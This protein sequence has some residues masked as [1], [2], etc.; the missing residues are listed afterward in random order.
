MKV[1]CLTVTR[2][3]A[4][5]LMMVV[6][7]VVGVFAFQ[8]VFYYS[9]GCSAFLAFVHAML[10]DASIHQVAAEGEGDDRVNA[11]EPEAQFS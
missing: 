3:E 6:S 4:S 11:L 7:I 8:E 2:K 9:I 10:R 5:A 1:L